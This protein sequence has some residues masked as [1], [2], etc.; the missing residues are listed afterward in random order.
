MS[1]KQIFYKL[2]NDVNKYPNIVQLCKT[3]DHG[4]KEVS[5]HIADGG[6]EVV[7]TP[8]LNSG[9]KIAT[10]SVDGDD[11]DIYAPG[12]EYGTT[13]GS[14]NTVNGSLV[15]ELKVSMV[16]VQDLH[17]YSKPW[18]GGAGKNKL[19]FISVASIKANN[20]SGT[21]SD[22]VYTYKDITFELK[23][24]A[25]GNF[26][27]VLINGTTTQDYTDFN[28]YQQYGVSINPFVSAGNYTIS[29][30]SNDIDVVSGYANTSLIRTTGP[31][32][33]NCSNGLS[34][35]FFRV[36]K[37]VTFTNFLVQPMIRLSSIADP[38]FEPYSNICPISGHTEA[39]GQINDTVYTT[40]LGT[41]VYGGELD[42]VSGE[43]DN[44]WS[45]KLTPT[46]V[47]SVGTYNDLVYWQ[48]VGGLSSVNGANAKSDQFE[49]TSEYKRGVCYITSAGS[50]LI[51]VPADQTLN[52]KALADAWMVANTPEF[53]YKLATPTTLTLTGQS[54]TAEVGEN[55]VSA[56]LDGQSIKEVK[57]HTM[58][59][60]DD[61]IKLNS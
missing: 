5:E 2:A 42:M 28:L 13:T 49:Q 23:L 36:A 18:A 26:I 1:L 34:W 8:L 21:W 40:S 46:S 52:T 24:D 4:F 61:V 15:D 9:K 58:M 14:F 60:I 27:G 51:V 12:L 3:L 44:G 17:G 37:N 56:P 32:S 30:N 33:G 48:V 35:A 7:V 45:S 59:T 11:S 39:K 25:D 19:A 43:G 29:S 6:S 10:I 55:N 53:V 57:Y 41:T 54:I 20:T 38:T 31:A 50:Q 16:P 22:D 47:A